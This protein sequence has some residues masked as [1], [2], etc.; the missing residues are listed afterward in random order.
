[1]AQVRPLVTS[2][3][4]LWTRLQIDGALCERA[5]RR[6]CCCSSWHGCCTLCFSRADHPLSAPGVVIE[7]LLRANA[8]ARVVQVYGLG[9]RLVQSMAVFSADS[10][11]FALGDT[12]TSRATGILSFPHLSSLC[13]VCWCC[14]P[15]QVFSHHWID[16]GFQGIMRTSTSR[17]AA[18]QARRDVACI[19]P[20]EG[21]SRAL[22]GLFL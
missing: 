19:R 6:R 16:V 9:F 1:M 22:C 11:L 13:D 3:C 15:L 20:P 8:W 14:Q 5:I 18:L 10:N 21:D 17:Q 12:E 7:K 4:A 2:L